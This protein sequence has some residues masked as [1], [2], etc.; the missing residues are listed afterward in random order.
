MK[1]IYIA[2]AHSRGQTLG[3]YI[4]YL[5]PE[6]NILA[7]LYDNDESN[8]TEINGIPV[9]HI[10]THFNLNTNCPVY[11]GTRGV[12]HQHLSETLKCCGMQHII[13]VDVQLDLDIR[14]AY[15]KKYYESI[16]RKFTKIDDLNS[17]EEK[18]N[19]T[20][21]IYVA[22]SVFDKPL[23]ENLEIKSYE[24]TIQVGTALTNKRIDAD[25]YDNEGE[26]ISNRNVHFCELTGLYWIWK[27]AE[28]DIVGLCHYRR[29]F[30]F[31]ENWQ[32]LMQSN[33]V[34]V[35]LPLPLYVA[36][37]IEENFKSRHI[38]SDWN[39]MLEYLKEHNPEDYDCAC[40]FFMETALY[41]P[42]NMFVMK[43]NIMDDMCRWLFPI[44]F[45]VT[46]HGGTKNDKYMNRY[47]GFISE[48]LITYF[49]EKNR[50]KY[51]V[52]YADK[53]FLS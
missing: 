28:E 8:P 26:N 40:R 46:E 47:P 32:R 3:K 23:Q 39:Y 44:L 30:V 49:F 18:E 19:K 31:P 11:L 37:N 15:L 34:D 2:G 1:N 42:C 51:K 45:A 29:H 10:D 21:C 38:A 16:G 22:V 9:I 53:N 7:Y 25:F 17:L 5:Y 48:R 33:D 35:I 36:P 13:P 20:T 4:T 27:H 24:K 50:E 6:V 52:V 14:N 12:N 41:S 43:K